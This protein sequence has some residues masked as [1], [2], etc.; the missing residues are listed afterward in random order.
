MTE[1]ESGCPCSQLHLVLATCC[2]RFGSINILQHGLRHFVPDPAPC[3]TYN[4]WFYNRCNIKKKCRVA[5]ASKN[6]AR[7]S[8]K[9]QGFCVAY[10][11]TLS[12]EK[13]SRSKIFYCSYGLKNHAFENLK[14]S[15][16]RNFLGFRKLTCSCGFRRS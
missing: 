15:N 7:Q 11:A 10:F 13:R 6:A 4:F 5:C 1:V 2:K 8:Q 9:T 14:G 12:D 16:V 3:Y